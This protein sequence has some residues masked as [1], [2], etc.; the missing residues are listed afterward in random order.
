MR[1]QDDEEESLLQYLGSQSYIAFLGKP[2]IRKKGDLSHLNFAV[3]IIRVII[4]A[5]NNRNSG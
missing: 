2:E 5:G 1:G 4:T 3:K